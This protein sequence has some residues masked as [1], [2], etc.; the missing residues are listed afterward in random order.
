MH[1]SYCPICN[2]ELNPFERFYPDFVCETCML[3]ATDFYGRPVEFFSI[4]DTGEEVRGEYADNQEEYSTPFC[5]INGIEC[6]AKNRFDNIVFEI[7]ESDTKLISLEDQ[8]QYDDKLSEIIDMVN[9]V[10]DTIRD[11]LF[12]LACMGKW[13][14]WSNSQTVGTTF[15][16][17]EDILRATGDKNIDLLI[18]I[19]D[20][21]EDC[22]FTKEYSDNQEVYDNDDDYLIE[23][24]EEDDT[25]IFSISEYA[26]YWEKL[27][28]IL[29]QVSIISDDI[30][31]NLYEFAYLK[32]WKERF[33]QK[34]IIDDKL[35]KTGDLNIELVLGI[36]EKIE[37]V[38]GKIGIHIIPAPAATEQKKM[39]LCLLP[40]ENVTIHI[41][42]S[43]IMSID[44]GDE[45]LIETHFLFP[46]ENDNDLWYKQKLEYG[47]IYRDQKIC[48]MIITGNDITHLRCSN[49][50]LLNLD[51]SNNTKLIYL[52]CWE[53]QL[54][55]LDVSKNTSLKSLQCYENQLTDLNLN[56]NIA[57]TKMDCSKNHLRSLNVGKNIALKNLNC[58]TNQLTTLDV[59]NNNLLE[60]LSCYDNRLTNLDLSNNTRL[61]SLSCHS[62]QLVSLDL[63]NNFVLEYLYCSN[64][65]LTDLNVSKS[66][67]LRRLYCSENRLTSL[68]VKNNAALTGLKCN[69]NQIIILDVS[70]NKRLKELY[71]DAN[72]LTNLDVSRN[73]ALNELSCVSNQ[74]RKLD[75]RKNTRLEKL[76]CWS[77]QLT[78]LNVNQ[79]KQLTNL[80]CGNN[81]LTDLDVSNNTKLAELYCDR[82]QL[83]NLDVSNNSKLTELDC[84]DN[85][86]TDLDIS[87]NTELTVLKCSGNE[88]E[89]MSFNADPDNPFEQN[90]FEQNPFMR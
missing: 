62:N 33:Y 74:I 25:K 5:Y 85:R 24:L 21:I 80:Y 4:N 12:T 59:S 11:N 28:E 89:D 63:S 68:N 6:R 20:I 77:N 14:K 44:W 72:Q 57:L 19:L 83:A 41:A 15:Y 65:Q 31:E 56:K 49:I 17:T 22:G 78:N 51:V 29:H 58:A 37:Q 81:I 53:N 30:R 3:M 23:A 61:S 76:W 7:V 71:C 69:K 67:M 46:C 70:K 43:G 34:T 66:I 82:N 75:I 13:R 10:S 79:N 36:L 40:T 73:S 48:T 26:S 87:A 90:P 55:S 32:K 2:E 47:H 42:G 84:R 64:N 16:V 88:F 60:D 35:R 50:Q 18:E 1:K 39:T 38:T 27:S 86:L 54:K 9:T 45:T 52:W 8:A